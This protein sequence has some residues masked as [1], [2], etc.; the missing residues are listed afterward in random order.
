MFFLG[1]LG[2]VFDLGLGFDFDFV[3]GFDFERLMGLFLDFDSKG[4]TRIGY[5]GY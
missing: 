2:L 1:V 5:K 4:L 3:R